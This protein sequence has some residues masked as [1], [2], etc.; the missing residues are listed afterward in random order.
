MIIA[1]GGA[2]GVNEVKIFDSESSFK[3]C[4]MLKDISRAVY[5]VDFSQ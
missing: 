1:G 5:S 4:C 3:P 2:N